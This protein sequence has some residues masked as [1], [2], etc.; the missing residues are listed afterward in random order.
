MVSSGPS[1]GDDISP[2]ILFVTRK[3][4]PAMGG[5]ETYSMKLTEQLARTHRVDV[6]ALPGRANGLPPRMSALLLFP[7]TILYH[8]LKRRR[9]PDV[10]HLGDMAIWPFGL[11]ASFRR[12]TQVVLS[13]HGTDV[14]YPRR[15]GWRGKLY[16]AYLR[17]GAAL[18]QRA[19]VIANSQATAEALQENGWGD[20]AI[21]PL[22]TDMRS[23]QSDGTHDGTILFAGRLV[24]RK[25]LG[26]FINEVLPSLPEGLILR[27]AGTVWD[28]GE[29]AALN[30][31][32][33]Q[34]LGNLTP[35]TLREGY[36]RALCVI[37][38]NIPVANGEF[39][40]FGLVAAEAA[41]AGALVL[42]AD[43]S[44]LKEAVI[45]G[46]TGFLLP[47]ADADAWRRKILEICHWSIAERSR[48]IERSTR[49]ALD[50]Y[51]WERVA[52]DTVSAYA[53]RRVAG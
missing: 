52:A 17:A 7:F 44:G 16:G 25:G 13:A 18:L 47:P 50:H 10:L 20:A 14:S 5:I 39:E 15:G 6:V 43:H 26:W 4:A 34:H 30:A 3:W 32:R 8:Y 42:A 24:K 19:Q 38:P 9:R 1:G 40:G 11:L 23:V 53:G 28:P 22:A 12:G 37:I 41:A 35:E 29:G 46:E 21:V 2:D 31:P 51:S 36:A 48:H 27:V 45:D 33:V 49:R